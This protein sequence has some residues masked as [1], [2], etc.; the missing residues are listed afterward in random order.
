[1]RPAALLLP[2]L[3]LVGCCCD[4][5]PRRDPYTIVCPSPTPEQSKLMVVDVTDLTATT[6]I[7]TLVERTRTALPA[8][9][10]VSRRGAATLI[11]RGT[12]E[13]HAKVGAWLAELRMD[14]MPPVSEP[15]P[16]PVT[17]EI[18]EVRDIVAA[19]GGN[20]RLLADLKPA[21]PDDAQAFLQGDATIVVKTTAAGQE[22]ADRWLA[23]RRRTVTPVMQAHSVFDL[24]PWTPIDALVE[25]LRTALP[26]GTEVNQQGTGTL[27]IKGTPAVQ[28]SA[29]RW[30]EE[31]RQT[32]VPAPSR[33][34]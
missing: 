30:I 33:T 2:V 6:P 22:A 21:L 8:G 3:G 1:M 13:A 34:R 5:T 12:P 32:V 18:Y 27:V 7:E 17:L 24:T 10:D 23:D 14:A 16:A 15:K 26:A 31:R 25:A 29:Q 19:T 9:S 28:E 4:R 20:E 11:I